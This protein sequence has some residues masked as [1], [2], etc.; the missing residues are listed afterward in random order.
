MAKITSAAATHDIVNPS[1]APA[2]TSSD[3]FR[4]GAYLQVGTIIGSPHTGTAHTNAH[5]PRSI[6]PDGTGVNGIRANGRGSV[7]AGRSTARHGA[8]LYGRIGS[9]LAVWGSGVRV[10][11]APLIEA[12]PA[13]ARG[14]LFAVR[15]VASPRSL[16]SL[17][18]GG[19]SLHPH[20]LHR[21]A[22]SVLRLRWPCLGSLRFALVPARADLLLVRSSREAAVGAGAPSCQVRG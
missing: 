11:S 17:P 14:A 21:W 9:S 13:Q 5:V 16:R 1:R 22:A 6:W 20:P 15:F 3:G 4:T 18:S 7:P 19:A 12:H 8:T 10:P 2:P